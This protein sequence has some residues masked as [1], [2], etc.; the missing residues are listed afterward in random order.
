MKAA[1]L[2]K[3]KEKSLCLLIV[4]FYP[5]VLL[6]F[7]LLAQFKKKFIGKAGQVVQRP[8]SVGTGG[9]AIGFNI[10]QGKK[11]PEGPADQ[12]SVALQ[13]AV[14]FLHGSDARRNVSP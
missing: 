7:F 8:A 14:P 4:L 13:I 2:S 6:S 9:G 10:A 3:K 5:L 11:M 1:P 12:V